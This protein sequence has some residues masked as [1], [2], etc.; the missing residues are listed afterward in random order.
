M[1]SLASLLLALALFMT[2]CT[3]SAEELPYMEQLSQDRYIGISFLTT[4]S[5]PE[6]CISPFY[7]DS[8]YI[9]NYKEP[10]FVHFACPPNTFASVFDD[11]S[12]R[13]INM[14]EGYQY[15]YTVHESDAF[16][17]FINNAEA[18]E[19]ILA[20]GSDGAAIYLDPANCQ[21]HAL[22]AAKE[23]GKSAKIE[24]LIYD[25]SLENKGEKQVIESLTP[26][27]KSDVARVQETMRVD[28]MEN[29]WTDARYAGIKLISDI[30]NSNAL[31]LTYT[32]P[33]GYIIA[34]VG[35]NRFAVFNPSNG[36]KA[37]L[38]L[39]TS[40][41]LDY[42]LEHDP[43]NMNYF[44]ADG[45]DY[46]IYANWYQNDHINSAYVDR[47]IAENVDY[48]AEHPLFVSFYLTATDTE[49][50][51]LEALQNDLAVIA[52][53]IQ[54]NFDQIIPDYR[55]AAGYAATSVAESE[56]PASPQTDTTAWKCPNCNTENQG[57]NFCP[58]CGTPRE[59]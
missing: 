45:N 51:S 8:M 39:S 1:K 29:Y 47:V 18:D 11:V 15:I 41:M 56:S 10:Y 55:D 57:G 38:Q 28:L 33:E 43:D 27:I 48:D 36:V 35:N 44:D 31:I 49:W 50:T 12:C 40:S 42:Y 2:V 14:D 6:I 17:T 26:L 4:D 54:P 37:T 7:I 52:S 24:I 34:G 59:A 22:I 53:G 46:R 3:A 19:Y 58:I 25:S 32:L 20:D 21:A 30:R 23:L 13:F 5:Y 16:E 9:R